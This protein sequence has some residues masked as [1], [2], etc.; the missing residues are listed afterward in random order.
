MVK[1]LASAL[2][3]TMIGLAVSGWVAVVVRD[4]MG[5]LF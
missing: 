2:M 1:V 5:R 4:T 3:A